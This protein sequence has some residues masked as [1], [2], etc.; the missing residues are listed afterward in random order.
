MLTTMGCGIEEDDG[1]DGVVALVIKVM[2]RSDRLGVGWLNAGR[3]APDA[4]F[5]VLLA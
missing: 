3:Q 1:N 4:D 5:S 2:D